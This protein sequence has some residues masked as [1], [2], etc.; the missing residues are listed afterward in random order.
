MIC[1]DDGGYYAIKGFL[2]QFDKSLIEIISN[3]NLLVNIETRQDIN[4]QDFV[5]QVKHKETQDYSD[6]KIR[7]PIIQ[8]LDLFR[9]DQTQSFCLYC[10][11]KNKQPSRW[12]LKLSELNDILGKNSNGYTSSLKSEFTN[13]FYI[14]FSNNFE[15]QFV[16][17]IGLIKSDF[18]LPSDDLAYYYHSLLR[19]KLL[20]ISIRPKKDRNVERKDLDELIKSTE[21][22][23]FYTAYSKY[24]DEAEYE[25]I[26]KKE[27]FTVKLANLENFERLFII[28]CNE[29][30]NHIEICKVINAILKKYFKINKSPQPYICFSSISN[31]LSIQSKQS[32]IDQGISFDDGT[33]FDGDRFRLEEIV[34]KKIQ[35]ENP[36]IKLIDQKYLKKLLEKVKFHEI[37]Q[38]YLYSPIGLDLKEDFVHNK[39]QII[40]LNQILKM[41]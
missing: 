12:Y 9:E 22:T 7:K 17:L 16:Q 18:S 39:I 25:K 30:D 32:L 34:K 28:E 6:Y 23:V 11:F 29:S 40:S 24:L 4:Y 38:F 26:V 3:P 15:E 13:R 36:K 35:F 14:E 19:S 1:E 41:L 8:L 37:Y 2:Y 21:K 33:Y 20:D 27:F 5:I 31:E 10:Y